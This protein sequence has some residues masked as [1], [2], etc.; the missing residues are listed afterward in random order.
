MKS[1]VWAFRGIVYC[2]GS[3]RNMRIHLSMAF[4]VIS[5]GLITKISSAQWTAALICIGAVTSLECVN[6]ALEELCNAL[7]PERSPAIAHVKD[8]A[9]GA[10][11]LSAIASA[12]VGGVIFINREKICAL[13]NFFKSEPV[14]IIPALL[15]LVLA[16]LFVKG[17]KGR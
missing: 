14:L 11:L 1:F 12:V 17:G 9:A 16:A 3:Q 15:S 6:T 7:H 2:V 10:V 4:Y 13:V 5:A 8:A